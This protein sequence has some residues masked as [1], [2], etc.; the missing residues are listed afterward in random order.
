MAQ[1]AGLNRSKINLFL[2]IGIAL[3]FA[4]EME[5]RFTGL[6]NHELLGLAVGAALIVHII[7]HWS[8]I[9]NVTRRFFKMLFHSS[10]LNYVLNIA[11]FVDMLVAVVSGIVIS[12]TLGLNLQNF[13]AGFNWQSIHILSSEMSLV[14]VA[15]HVAV[16]WKWIAAHSKKYLFSVRLP[17]P[18]ISSPAASTDQIP[19]V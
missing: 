9:V 19:T 11:L 8:W 14:I 12:R 10:R 13:G 1:K 15:L 7:L 17:W 2:D 5:E 4:I 3:A 6:R 16:H 18:K